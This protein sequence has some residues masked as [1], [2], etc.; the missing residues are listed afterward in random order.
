[1]SLCRMTTRPTSPAVVENAVERRVGQAGGVAGDLRGDELLVD[2]ELADPREDAREGG[3]HAPDVI[4]GIHVRR[5]EAG[6]HRIEARLLLF[7]QRPVRHRDEGVGERVVVERR[8]GLQVVGRRE[9]AGVAVR[10]LLLQRDAEERRPPDLVAHDLQEVVNVG[11]FLDVVRE[12]EVVVVDEVGRRRRR[13]GGLPGSRHRCRHEDG[14][15]GHEQ[16]AE[17]A[18]KRDPVVSHEIGS[19]SLRVPAQKKIENAVDP[20]KPSRPPV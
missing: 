2:G 4:R 15:A 7:R 1:M 19:L 9:V 12:V 13:R 17:R 10:P 3:Q 11:A 16:H 20:T 18:R 8:V 6:D 14:S 5:V